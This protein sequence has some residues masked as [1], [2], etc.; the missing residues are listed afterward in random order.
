M[1][2]ENVTKPPRMTAPPDLRRTMPPD[3]VLAP[4]HAPDGWPLRRLD[5]PAERPRGRLL[6]QGGR[7]DFIEKY[8]ES[9]G[10]FRAAGWSV[11]G[12]DWR[13]QGGSG[14]LCAD[15]R[16]GHATSFMPWVDDLAALWRELSAPGSGPRVAL[17]HSMGGYLVLQALAERRIDPDAVVLVAPM[18]GLRSP[19]GAHWGGRVARFM[20]GRGDP[21]RPAWKG[22]E[23]PA[24]IASRQQ[25]LTHDAAR[26]DDE[27]WWTAHNPAIRL[28]P[29]SWT[30]VSEA[31]AAT[32]ALERDRRIESIRTPILM[33]VADADRLVDPRAAIRIAGRLPNATLVRFGPESAH[34]I[35]READPVRNRALAAIETF[36]QEQVH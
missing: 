29:P 34:E 7:G 9:F 33:L 36:L 16:V 19:L 15:P 24:S 18:L 35:L 13:G 8:L 5:W 22:N 23:R 11:T 21:A 28:G 14:R 27:R 3:A 26:Y 30:W 32:R 1:A 12:F 31:F 20:A 25:L 10:H 4:W 17:G 6:F 2:F